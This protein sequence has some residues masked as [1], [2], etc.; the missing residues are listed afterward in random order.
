MNTPKVSV[1][2][3]VFNG[4]RFLREAVESILEQSYRSFEFIIIDDGSTD[5]TAQI[6]EEFAQ[7]DRRIRYYPQ[8]NRGLIDAL[9]RGCRLA[10][11][12]FLARMDADDISLPGRLQWQ[13]DFLEAHP[14]IGMVGGAAEFIDGSGEHIC[15]APHPVTDEEIRRAL[16]DGNVFWH[17]SI[18]LRRSVFLSVGGYRNLK[19]AEDYDLWLRIA[20]QSQV[21]NLKE[22]ILKY[23]VHPGQVS[24]T[25]CHEQAVST[26]MARAAASLR[27]S[28]KPDP[29]VKG[30][31]ITQALLEELNITEAMVQTTVAR[32]YLSTIRNMCRIGEYAASL[33]ALKVLHSDEFKMA[34]KWVIADSYLWKAR[35]CWG[36]KRPAAAMGSYLH[37]LVIRPAVLVRP[38]R[39]FV[40]FVKMLVA[41]SPGNVPHVG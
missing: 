4:E 33:N 8:E 11:A 34:E 31:A 29:F 18:L 21:A 36:K 41:T 12:D 5:G 13:V 19:L 3:S 20:E 9:N 2:M 38:I 40:L 23:R 28:G 32:G 35:A 30:Q 26:W 7:K 10:R 15:V 37:A 1:V 17:P 27:K 16:P 22:V 24:V 39:D 6:L 14:G 25:S